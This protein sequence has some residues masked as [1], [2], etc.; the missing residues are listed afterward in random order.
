MSN[1]KSVKAKEGK[2]NIEGKDYVI[3]FT[4][5]SFIELEEEYG[6]IDE[7]MEAI[8]GIP[9][10]D[11]DTKEPVMETVKDD[12]TGKEIVQQKR[13]VS[14]KA[15]RKF[16]WV[17]L[18]TKQPEMKEEDI[19]N[20]LTLVNMTDVMKTIMETFGDSLPKDDTEGEDQKN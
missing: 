9:V 12:E 19:G 14:L 5:N 10:F 20:L 8:K 15:I 2:I 7:A 13:R 11:K 16:L 18:M 17:G 4:M 3:K 1:A 6:S